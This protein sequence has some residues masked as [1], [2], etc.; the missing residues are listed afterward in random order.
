MW[1]R[2]THLQL[3]VEKAQLQKR[4]QSC[5][6][7]EKQESSSPPQKPDHR[8]HGQAGCQRNPSHGVV[9]CIEVVRNR[10][11]RFVPHHAFRKTVVYAVTSQPRGN[12]RGQEDIIAEKAAVHCN[13][14]QL[15]NTLMGK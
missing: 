7:H 10:H 5:K 4:C 6:D 1:S 13:V 3:T 15:G 11:L 14:I 8:A 2:K 12:R 9:V